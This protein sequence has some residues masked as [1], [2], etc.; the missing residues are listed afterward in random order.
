MHKYPIVLKIFEKTFRF[1]VPANSEKEA[2]E[3]GHKF[4]LSKMRIELE[5][6]NEPIKKSQDGAGNT[7][8]NLGEQF[9]D[10]FGSKGNVFDDLFG[11]KK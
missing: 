7:F 10:I 4:V 3:K 2:I 5:E 6:Q 9:G 1:N 8:W 11:K